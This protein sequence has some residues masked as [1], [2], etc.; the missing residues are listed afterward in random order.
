MGPDQI[1]GVH[2]LWLTAPG[3]ID[4]PNSNP[5]NP[6]ASDV[7]FLRQV[8]NLSPTCYDLVDSNCF[9]VDYPALS[10]L[11]A[12][13]YVYIGN[14]YAPWPD[15]LANIT[16]AMGGKKAIFIDT[17]ADHGT[18]CRPNTNESNPLLREKDNCYGRSS[19]DVINRQIELVQA[20]GVEISD[21]VRQD[22]QAMC[23]SAMEF[24]R[25]ARSAQE[26]G[27]RFLMGFGVFFDEY[28][29]LLRDILESPATR[30]M[31]ELGLPI[32]HL[33]ACS[34]C[35]DRFPNRQNRIEAIP[36]NLWFHKCDPGQSF[37]EC[38]EDVLYPVDVWLNPNGSEDE[39]LD[40]EMRSIF[41]DKAVLSNQVLTF[42]FNSG[43]ISPKQLNMQ[44]KYWATKINSFERL[45]NR[46][47]CVAVDVT[48]SDHLN[49]EFGALEGGQYAC[50]N[51]EYIQDL[52]HK[53]PADLSSHAAGLVTVSAGMLLTWLS[54]FIMYLAHN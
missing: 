31:E 27:L 42:P 46:T 23:E 53:C 3:Q 13:H 2:G 12:D 38:N 41:P 18:G 49:L 5:H 14:G 44:L 21:R 15:I 39:F 10:V 1:V 50:F 37:E 11:N 16:T 33:G 9:L 54:V 32:L 4:A 48:T 28:T 52:Y 30:T 22:Q 51:D 8:V 6:D 34:E 40:E 25:A 47:S 26:R 45:H 35:P 24:T 43:A 29:I 20:L 7:E 36:V 17:T 19:I